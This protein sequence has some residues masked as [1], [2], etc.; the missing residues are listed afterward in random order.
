MSIISARTENTAFTKPFILASFVGTRE[1]DRRQEFR[2]NPVYYVVRF[3]T[4]DARLRVA[5]H[6]YLNTSNILC[7]TSLRATHDSAGHV[8]SPGLE[9]INQCV[10][11]NGSMIHRETSHILRM[12]PQQQDRDSETRR[13]KGLSLCA[14]RHKNSLNPEPQQAIT[15][16]CQGRSNNN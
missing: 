8:L 14:Y 10:Q 9:V 12:R 13:I 6:Q 16:M 15:F 4:T 5:P 11:A 2:K 7:W 1:H 3:Q